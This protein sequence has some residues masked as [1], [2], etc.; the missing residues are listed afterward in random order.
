MAQEC[1]ALS[2]FLNWALLARVAR[3]ALHLEPRTEQGESDGVARALIRWYSS[4]T[5]NPCEGQQQQ[6]QLY[7]DFLLQEGGAGG[8]GHSLATGD[9]ER[10]VEHEDIP[11]QC[12]SYEDV[13][14]DV[15]GSGSKDKGSGRASARRRRSAGIRK[16]HSRR[17]SAAAS[18]LL[19]LH[20]EQPSSASVAARVLETVRM[21]TS[22]NVEKD[23]A[24][25]EKKR[26]QGPA[27]TVFLVI[28]AMSDHDSRVHTIVGITDHAIDEIE[29]I[30]NDRRRNPYRS[31]HKHVGKWVMLL[32]ASGFSDWRTTHEYFTQWYRKCRGITSRAAK[33][34]AL[35]KHYRSNRGQHNLKLFS[36]STERDRKLQ[37]IR[38][39]LA[40]G[41]MSRVATPAVLHAI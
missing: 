37:Q 6:Q 8:F 3:D 2:D 10:Q 27:W 40:S 9:E 19:S 12:M 1:L 30:F 32:A 33:G 31:T 18:T 24:I 22:L 15:D 23:H 17:A 41:E 20:K 5:A 4:Q 11:L 25:F 13:D 21:I 34:I 7:S 28:N 35:Y 36:V 14:V 29:L 16:Q 39:W 38:D 26:I